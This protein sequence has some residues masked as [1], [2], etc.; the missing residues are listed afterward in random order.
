MQCTLSLE[1]LISQ[2]KFQPEGLEEYEPENAREWSFRDQVRRVI[3]ELVT[4]K[5]VTC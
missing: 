5:N 3:K 1:H 2:E 4:V